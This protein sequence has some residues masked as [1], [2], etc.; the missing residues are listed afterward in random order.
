MAAYY[1][2][3]DQQKAEW[4]LFVRTWIVAIPSRSATL[5][6]VRFERR[7]RK[8]NR[9]RWRNY[10]VVAHPTA[11]RQHPQMGADWCERNIWN[12]FSSKKLRGNT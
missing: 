4:R 3:I 9:V 11:P 5:G 7:A 12:Y 6:A 1:N 2:E 8:R 10:G